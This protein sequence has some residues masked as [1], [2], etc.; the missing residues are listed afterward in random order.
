MPADFKFDP[1]TRD[2]VSDGKGSFVQTTTAETT[3]LHQMTCLAGASWHDE[4]LGTKL[5]DL[6]AFP[7]NDPATWAVDEAK[8]ALGVLVSRGRIANVEAIAEEQ[9]GG[10][11]AIA[12]SMQDV[13][14]GG[15]INSLVKAGG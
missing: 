12:T 3:V 1:V 8:R 13:S 11:V 6:Q 15:V 7:Q 10:R 5:V 14:T 9:P 2:I 4:N